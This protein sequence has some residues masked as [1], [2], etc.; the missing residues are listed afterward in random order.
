[1]EHAQ[2]SHELSAAALREWEGHVE[3]ALRGV[4][5]ALNNRAAS[6][7][8]VVE[9]WNEPESE[10]GSTR[11]LL[12]AEVQRLRDLVDVVYTVGAPRGE[13]EAFEPADAVRTARAVIGLHADLREHRITIDVASA[14]PVRA[15]QWML[16]RAL[17]ALAAASVAASRRY[18]SGAPGTVAGTVAIEVDGEAGWVV[19]RASGPGLAPG[20]TPY[21]LETARAMGGE[22]LDDALGFRLPSLAE[23]RRREGR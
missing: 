4:A 17:G 7:S 23:L 14:P 11:R 10:S 22:P 21:V 6:V 20:L 12:E 9:L 16:V 5:H 18:G 1:M 2:P 8:A 15:R 3:S 19:I 13:I